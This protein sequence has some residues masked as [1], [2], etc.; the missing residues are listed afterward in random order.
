MGKILYFLNI[1]LLTGQVLL[2]QEVKENG[3]KKFYYPNGQV[4]SEGTMRN[5]KPDGYWKT[6]YVTGVKKSEGK[7]INFILDSTWVFYNQAGDTIEKINYKN[8]RKNGFYIK[9]GNCKH[10]IQYSGCI[11]SKELYVNDKREGNA[12]YYYS[13]GELKQEIFYKKGYKEGIAKEYNKNGEIITI[14]EYHNNTLVDRQPINRKDKEGKK[15]GKWITFYQNGRIMR[16]EQYKNGLLNGYIKEYDQ[17]GNIRLILFYKDGKIVSDIN[18]NDTLQMPVDIRNT[19]D[20]NGDLFEN[21]PYKKNIPI[22]IHR[23]YKDGKIIN[24]IIYDNYGEKIS[25]GIINEK[26]QKEGSWKN[27][28][29]DGK[30]QSTGKYINNQR[31]GIW[32]FYYKNGKIE[33]TGSFRSG[34]ENGEWKWYFENGSLRRE[35]SYFN[36]K[37]D[38]LYT[39]YDREGNIIANGQYLDGERDGE[40]EIQ[41]GDHK[42]TG[43]YILGLREGIWKYYYG[44]GKIQYEGN[45]KRGMADGRHKIYYENG[46]L[47]EEQ[48]YVMGSREK[49][50]KKYD[51]FGNLVMTISYKNDLERRI[52]GVKIKLEKEVKTIK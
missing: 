1:F 20:K 52:N 45:Y 26:G 36:G 37:R 21:G 30:V 33:Q 11:K 44:N 24:S 49:T 4:S 50:W 10:G 28:Y 19:Y 46:G 12:E 22:G 18:D 39:E 34:K 51:E 17:N 48:F 41:V 38:G 29:Y 13:T 3:Y 42:E 2:S 5:G 7:R 25:E 23:F 35:E 9:Y 14:L 16:E 27:Y 40:W 32:K 43:K 15:T 31:N 47:K 6:Y 8:G